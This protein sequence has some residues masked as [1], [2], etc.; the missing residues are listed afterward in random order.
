MPRRVVGEGRAEDQEA[1]AIAQEPDEERQQ[2]AEHVERA[3]AGG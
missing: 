1:S 2:P 3:H